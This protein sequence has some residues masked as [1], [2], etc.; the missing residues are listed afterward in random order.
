M[1]I[2][3]YPDENVFGL[4]AHLKQISV[5]DGDVVTEL[6]PLGL[7]G[8]TGCPSCGEHL[9]LGVMKIIGTP[10][11]SPLYPQPRMGKK[12][13]EQLLFQVQPQETPRFKPFCSY[14]APNGM[15]FS[16]QDPSGWKGTD[17]DPWTYDKNNGGCAIES[18]YFWKFEIDSSS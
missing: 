14:T 12:D 2:V 1:V 18:P 9:H 3:E 17:T 15:R 6:T 16:F 13:W 7:M 10:L 11:V 8:N 5:N 4:Y